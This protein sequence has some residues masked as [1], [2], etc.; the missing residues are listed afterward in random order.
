LVFGR[1][2]IHGYRTIFPI[3]L[4][5][6]A[7]FM[8]Q[9]VERAAA[10]AALE[11]RECG[12]DWT[13]APMVDITRDP[14][15][16]RVAE[17]CGEDPF[18]T[19]KMGAAMV[20]GFQGQPFD[21][22]KNVAACAKHYVGYGASESGKD[23]N[24]TWIPDAL[25]FDLHLAPFKACVDAGV[26]T[27]MSAFNDLNGVPASG[28]EVTIR[29]VL[30]Q[31]WGFDGFVVSD[32]ASL[33][34]MIAHGYCRDGSEV[35]RRGLQAG[36]D[37]EMASRAY[38]DHLAELVTANVVP[39]ASV[40][41]AA[42]RVLGIKERLGLFD[43][44]YVSAPKQSSILTPPHRELAR[45]L[46]A[47]SLVL[48]KN[49]DNLL[50]LSNQRVALVGPLADH[51]RDQLGCWTLD[52]NAEDSTTLR[53]ALAE[54]LGDR[55]AFATGLP[56]CRSTD[57]SGFEAAAAVVAE[58]DVAIV[59]V[60]ED[61]NLSGECRSRA[62]L[63]LPGAQQA[64][65][66]RLAETGTP[67]VVVFMAGRP[68]T[69]QGACE[70]ASAA[71]YAW[72]AGTEAGPA[73][74]NVLFG[75]DAPGGKLPISFPRATGQIPVYYAHKNTGRPPATDFKGIPEG[76]PLDPVGF[77]ASYLDLEVTPLYPFGFGLSYTTF[78]FTDLAVEPHR[79]KSGTPVR[80]SVRIENTGQRRGSEVAQL[81]VR[82]LVGSVT[83]PVRELKGFER[84]WLDPGES[85][86]VE[87]EL[88][89]SDLAFHDHKLEPCVEPGTFQVFAGSDSSATLSAQFEIE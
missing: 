64:L 39:E 53:S 66:R 9:L 23:Y 18:L 69:I 36:V 78:D 2:V 67:L 43:E 74:A 79:A 85:R 11:A 20:R 30:K 54:R 52:G 50:P 42:A 13:F 28:N 19:S 5:Q 12:I 1:D 88:T 31:R 56:D 72:H 70:Q 82:D 45:E 51:G 63:D 10:V 46:A 58:S 35:A 7:S 60:G 37:M 84:L 68:L 81:Y 17:T 87:F 14:R 38:M 32:W 83:R 6:A 34:E 62:F 57:E 3:P 65:L 21:R 44:P 15:W 89:E 27:L 47:R 71:L 80:V 24:T 59:V 40:D 41:D 75:D 73:L 76:T 48:L 49:D 8:P 16:G 26:W 25:L 22:L 4:G 86:V 55:L 77:D 29:D 61:Y 33:W